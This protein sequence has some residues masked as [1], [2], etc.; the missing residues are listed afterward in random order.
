MKTT[1]GNAAVSTTRGNADVSANRKA[2][3][4]MNESAD[5]SAN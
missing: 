1:D 5:K 4:L 3:V 2:V